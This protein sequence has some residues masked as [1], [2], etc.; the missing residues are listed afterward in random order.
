MAGT[1]RLG[2]KRQPMPVMVPLS[3]RKQASGRWRDPQDVG[4]TRTWCHECGIERKAVLAVGKDE[5]GA[6][7]CL[8]HAQRSLF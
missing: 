5:D 2:R 6:P 8:E 1:I 7:A 4:R 3:Q